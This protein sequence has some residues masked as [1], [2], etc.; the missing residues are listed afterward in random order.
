[1]ALLPVAD[2][3]EQILR[4]VEPLPMESVALSD[5]LGR[6]LAENLLAQGNQP[7]NDLSAMD[8][9]AVRG[10]DVGTSSVALKVMG[11]A[12]AGHPFPKEIGPAE[13]PR[14]FTGGVLPRVTDT[15]GI[16]EDTTRDGDRV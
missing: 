6:V 13:C 5:A 14:I 1:M 12:A 11:E 10:D 16:Q 7:P 8:C 9:Y 4:G 15:V 2:A 3:I